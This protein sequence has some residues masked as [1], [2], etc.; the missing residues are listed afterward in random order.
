MMNF[1]MTNVVWYDGVNAY[2]SKF[3]LEYDMENNLKD[4]SLKALRY[5]LEGN[6]EL[7]KVDSLYPVNFTNIVSMEKNGTDEQKVAVQRFRRMFFDED[8]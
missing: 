1:R 5:Y 7:L 8:E 4:E 3:I 6:G 2:V